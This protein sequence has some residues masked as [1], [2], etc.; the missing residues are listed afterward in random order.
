MMKLGGR[1]IVQ[2]SWPSSNLGVM[3]PWVH[4]P[5]YVAFCYDVEK[6]STGWL[7]SLWFCAVDWAGYLSTFKCIII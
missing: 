4:T 5:K 2:Q 7:V 6:I 3:A 1:C